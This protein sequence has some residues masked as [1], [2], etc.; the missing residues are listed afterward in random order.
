MYKHD[1][2][3]HERHLSADFAAIDA[4]ILC[5]AGSVRISAS[6]SSVPVILL[7]YITQDLLVLTFLDACCAHWHYGHSLLT[8]TFPSL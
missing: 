7:L 5:Q 3:G 1:D 6:R 2:S 4:L 8:S